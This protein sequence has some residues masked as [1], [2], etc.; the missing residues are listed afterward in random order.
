LGFVQT[1][2]TYPK[3][4]ENAHTQKFQK[5]ELE[6]DSAGKTTVCE[7]KTTVFEFY[8]YDKVVKF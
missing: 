1:Q 6:E 5:F 4:P 7:G 2:R 3:I 8:T